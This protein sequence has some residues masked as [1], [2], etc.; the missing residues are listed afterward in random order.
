MEGDTTETIDPFGNI[1]S[2]AEIIIDLKTAAGY[3][4]YPKKLKRGPWIQAAGETEF[5]VVWEA[6][7]TRLDAIIDKERINLKIVDADG[8]IVHNYLIKND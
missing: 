7:K 6:N 8:K 3:Q 4:C 2:Q 1:Y 5:T